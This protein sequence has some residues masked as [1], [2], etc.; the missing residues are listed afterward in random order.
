MRRTTSFSLAVLVCA[1]L[2]ARA[3]RAGAQACCAGAGALTPGR[4]SLHEDALV[5]TQVHT[6]TV[7]GSYD[8]VGHFASSASAGTSELDFEEDLF[9]AL[10]VLRR[11]QVALLVPLVETWRS[12]YQGYSEIGGGI[13]DMNLSVRY[14]LFLAGQSRILPGVAVLAGVTAP[15]GRPPDKAHQFLA[16]DATGVGAWQAN[17]GVALEQLY[18]PWL[19][20]VT[21][22][23]AW[24]APRNVTSAGQSVD[25]AL[26]P[27]FVTLVGGA[28]SFRDEGS[29]AL[30]G[31]YTIEGQASLNG[32][33]E[34]QSARRLAVVTLSAAHPLTDAW[35]LQG[36]LFMNPPLSTLGR[37][38]TAAAGITF[39]LIRS[40][41]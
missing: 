5:G 1:A 37:N 25:E 18:G 32:G 26:A 20:N 28:Y 16:T 22:L 17:G 21:Q 38:Q 9:G 10:R 15:T 36:G 3:R 31:S 2:F 8:N 4:L 12:D 40:W 27:Q 29:I 35:R 23:V 19:V 14:D 30:F 39:T 34:L 24:R 11:G 33:P 41:S 13:G 7:L 6:G